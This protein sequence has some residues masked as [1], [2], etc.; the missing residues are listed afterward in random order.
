LV[1]IRRLLHQFC[2]FRFLGFWWL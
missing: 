1:R 2:F